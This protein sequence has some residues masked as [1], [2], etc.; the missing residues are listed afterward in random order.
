MI[1]G[2]FPDACRFTPSCS[3]YA[4]LALQK[5]GV[6]KGCWFAIMRLSKCHPLYNKTGYDPVP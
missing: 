6:F 3:N 4:I 1:S 5:H 2:F